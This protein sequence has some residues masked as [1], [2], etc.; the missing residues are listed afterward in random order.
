MN[1]RVPIIERFITKFIKIIHTHLEKEGEEGEGEGGSNG[2]HYFFFTRESGRKIW[3]PKIPEKC[4][5]DLL[6]KISWREGKK[7]KR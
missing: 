6:V 7:V 4:P 1:R 5:L 2:R 3:A